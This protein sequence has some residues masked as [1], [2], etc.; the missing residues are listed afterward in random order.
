[1]GF[2]FS[3]L[4]S[5]IATLV[6]L[7]SGKVSNDR[8]RLA[9]RVVAALIGL[10]AVYACISRAL[11]IVPPGNIGVAN[12]FGR[13]ADNTFNP[14]INLVNPFAKV[15]NFST[16][17]KD[18]KENVDASSQEGLNLNIDVSLQYKIDPQKVATVYKTIGTSETELIISRFRSTIRSI[19]AQYP[20]NDIYSNKRQEVTNKINE[21]LTQELLP[22]GF[23]VEKALLRNVQMPDTIQT[24]IQAK[25]KAEQENQQMKF[26][27]EKQRQEA[28]RKRIEAK[29]IADSQK[30]ISDGLTNQILQLR[31]IEATEKLAQS[32]NSKIIVVGSG[33][34]ELPIL[35]QEPAT[36]K[37]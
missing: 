35:L 6:Y 20:A 14:G 37:P 36:T 9:V 28:E 22:L 18:I 1:M 29:G 16:R 8:N 11:V 21:Q 17:L 4:T 26:I 7:N 19:I 3:L 15:L 10:I 30:I 12:L 33:K 2:I 32:P 23:V 25:L 24:A 31:T 5:L 27:L 13:V 34:G